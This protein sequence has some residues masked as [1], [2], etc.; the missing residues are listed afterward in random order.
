MSIS[1]MI[2]VYILSWWLCFFIALPFGIK[3][4]QNPQTGNDPGA[5]VNPHLKKKALICFG[6]AAFITALFWAGY[7]FDL[8]TISRPQ[9]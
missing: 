3:R 4:D 2:V 6:A 1:S 7:H 5:P 9:F 8:V